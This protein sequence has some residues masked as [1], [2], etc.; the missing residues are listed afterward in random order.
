MKLVGDVNTGDGEGRTVGYV[1]DLERR[2]KHRGHSRR[3]SRHRY[4][5]NDEE[6]HKSI[7]TRSLNGFD[8]DFGQTGGSGVLR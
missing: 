2:G 1:D 8:F 4:Q 6:R 3:I 7:I 5:C